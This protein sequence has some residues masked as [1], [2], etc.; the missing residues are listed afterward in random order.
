MELLDL[1][2]AD[3]LDKIIEYAIEN[4]KLDITSIKQLIKDDFF[5]IIN[6]NNKQDILK[7]TDIHGITRGCD[8]YEGVNGVTQS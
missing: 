3:V 7:S 1:Y 4:N 8:Y 2:E 5:K 6:S